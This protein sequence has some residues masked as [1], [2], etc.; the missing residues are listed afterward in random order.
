[1]QGKL[2]KTLLLHHIQND[3]ETDAAEDDQAAGRQV[4]KDV[5]LIRD[6]IA[7]PAQDVKARVVE[8]RHGMEHAD[9]ERPWQGIIP[10]EHEKAQDGSRNLKKQRHQKDRPHQL[11]DP[12]EAVHIQ[13]LLGQEPSPDADALSG[14]QD[15]SHAHGGDA[16]SAD[17]DQHRHHRLPEGGKMIRHVN[18]DQTRHAYGAGGGEQ[19]V[20]KGHLRIRPDGNGQHQKHGAGQDHRREAHRD[21][22][23]GRLLFQ[24]IYEKHLFSFPLFLFISA[25]KAPDRHTPA[26]TPSA[27]ACFHPAA[28]REKKRF[29]PSFFFC[30]K[31]SRRKRARSGFSS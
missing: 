26:H 22:P 8:G 30:T 18:G 13:S 15:Q 10:A 25:G 21:Q 7:Q 3:Q 1:M 29:F 31:S 9:P 24:K 6:Q 11:D 27:A 20:H 5:V 4:Q 16:E 2:F 23:S 12:P 28:E 14:R 17:L 19:S